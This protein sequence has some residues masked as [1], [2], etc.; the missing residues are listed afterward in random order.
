MLV[1]ASLVWQP[2]NV[3]T[4]PCRFLLALTGYLPERRFEYFSVSAST[5]DFIFNRL[6]TVVLF[7]V[8]YIVQTLR[9]PDNFVVLNFPMPRRWTKIGVIADGAFENAA[10]WDVHAYSIKALFFQNQ[11]RHRRCS[12]PCL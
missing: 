2:L 3:D 8:R 10:Q 9:A 11:V 4:Q 5:T 1:F 12:C 6:L 7:C